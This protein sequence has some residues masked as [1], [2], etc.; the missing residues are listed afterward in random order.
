MSNAPKIR[1][2]P[3]VHFDTDTYCAAR[4][5]IER[6]EG[7]AS[8]QD[9]PQKDVDFIAK[10]ILKSS[11]PTSLAIWALLQKKIQILFAVHPHIAA[12]MVKVATSGDPVL[13]A[14]MNEKE[15]IA[16]VYKARLEVAYN[17]YI[18]INKQS[19]G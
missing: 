2:D 7:I 9:M 16:A 5:R 15:D 17:E 1:F 14:Y 8:A 3:D 4:Y 12:H 19:V 10:S 6:N 11:M 13:E 18:V